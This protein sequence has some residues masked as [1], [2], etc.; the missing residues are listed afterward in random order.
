MKT[1]STKV[2]R[3]CTCTKKVVGDLKQLI[4]KD[5]SLSSSQINKLN[6]L[7]RKILIRFKKI[8]QNRLQQINLFYFLNNN[9][10]N[11]DPIQPIHFYLNSLKSLRI[12]HQK[13]NP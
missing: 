8:Y 3:N 2:D 1:P 13:D 11:K 12:L 10:N 5:R 6:H 7:E 4:V 9:I